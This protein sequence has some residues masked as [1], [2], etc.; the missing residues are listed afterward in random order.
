[1]A[2]IIRPGK[3]SDLKA[4]QDL[5]LGLFEKEVVDYDPLLDCAWPHDERGTQ[6]FTDRLTKPG[7]FLA[8]VENEAGKLVGYL[9]G[10]VE[11][12]ED[13]R[14]PFKLAELADMFVL[15]E[16]R[17]QGVGG[18]LVDAFLDWCR[19]NKVDVVKVVASTGNVRGLDFY[20]AHGFQ[21]YDTT[22][23]LKLN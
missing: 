3:I 2:I 16:C 12:C 11:K 21:D 9:S 17:G 8:V 7:N 20:K 23:E 22:L 6:Y 15:P 1:M 10:G 13:F 14:K 19:Q 4:I 18:R 5:S